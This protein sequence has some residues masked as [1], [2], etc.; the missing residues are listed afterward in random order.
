M[1][2]ICCIASALLIGGVLFYTYIYPR[3]K[4]NL[5]VLLV[6]LSSI[7]C[8]SIFRPGVYESGDFMI[9]IYRTI[10]F[11]HSLQEGQFL[12]SWAAGLN[13]TYGYPLFIFNYPLPYYFISFFH[14][15]GFSFILSMK[16]FLATNFILSG[17]FMY[18][19]AKETFKNTVAAFT[20]A[21]F[22]LFAPYHLIDLHFKNVIGEILVFTILPLTFYFFQK[23]WKEKTGL[24]L[25]LASLSVALLIMSHVVLALFS[26]ILIFGY[27]IFLSRQKEHLL[28]T[29]IP[30]LL[31]SIATLYIW[32]T[33]FFMTQY[34]MFS[35]AT[36]FVYFPQFF[37]LLYAP[38]RMGFLFQGHRG[39]LSF[40]LGYTHILVILSLFFLFFRKMILSRYKTSILFWLVV[41]CL[42]IFLI[43]P[44]SKFLWGTFTFLKVTGSHRLLLLAAFVSSILAGYLSLHL[45]RR[46]KLL[47]ILLFITVFSTIL[48]WGHRRVIPAITEQHIISTVWKSTAHGEGH[49]Y[50]N[51]QY[52]SLKDPWFSKLPKTPIEFVSGVGEMKALKHNSL[53]HTYIINAKTPVTIRENTLYFPGWQIWSNDKQITA[54]PDGEGVTTFKLPKGLYYI[55]MRYQ[56]IIIYKQLKM[57]SLAGFISLLG[58]L[59][60]MGVKKIIISKAFWR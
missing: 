38:W 48:N 44:A 12:P 51:S 11:Y 59:C 31:G 47:I 37:E 43:T 27:A 34:T 14:A 17:I 45:L 39:E 15:F 6:L 22:Y 52:R 16:M 33:P 28:R 21:I 60:F 56:D 57:I 13:A 10:E 58:Y 25:A 40:L 23:L 19:F 3:K 53:N 41:L 2:L 32:A 36:N 54:I 29:C 24:W 5:F 46:K 49:F 30:L 18:L 50:A 20:T 7:V 4:I 8:I 42:I 9:H 1:V 26:M 35:Q 55:D